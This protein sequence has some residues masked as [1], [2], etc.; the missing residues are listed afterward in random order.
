MRKEAL[1]TVI[2]ILYKRIL[3][4]VIELVYFVLSWHF[5]LASCICSSKDKRVCKQYTWH[6]KSRLCWSQWQSTTNS[7]FTIKH[8]MPQLDQSGSRSHFPSASVQD[9]M[10]LSRSYENNQDASAGNLSSL[11]T[12]CSFW[13]AVKSIWIRNLSFSILFIGCLSFSVRHPS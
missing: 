10:K 11:H 5:I 6:T 9:I 2:F 13:R 3:I 8:L 12:H 1:Q 7:K 4:Y